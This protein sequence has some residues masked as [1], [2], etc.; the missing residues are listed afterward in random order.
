MHTPLR[1][2]ATPKCNNP[3]RMF[4]VARYSIASLRAAKLSTHPAT[5]HRYVR[6][7][8]SFWNSEGPSAPG[9]RVQRSLLGPI[10]ALDAQRWSNATCPHLRSALRPHDPHTPQKIPF[11]VIGVSPIVASVPPLWSQSP[12]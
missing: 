9:H 11:A 10:D 5:S 1:A 8:H 3:L 2:R 6:A 4:F 7:H 12:G